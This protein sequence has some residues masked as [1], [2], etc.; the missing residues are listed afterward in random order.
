MILSILLA[1]ICTVVC[2]LVAY[3][4]A[5]VLRYIN[6][7]NKGLVIV[8]LILPMWMN[9]IL[10]ILALQMILNK[11]GILNMILSRFSIGPFEMLNTRGAIIFGMVY[12]FLPYMILPIYNAV[13]DIDADLLDA[14]SDLGASKPTRLFK[15]I[16][17]L[18]KPGIISGITMVFIPALTSFVIPDVLGGG[19]I[20]LI[21]NVIEQE[22]VTS[23]NWHL[24]AGLSFALLIFVIIGLL[25]TQRQETKEKESNVW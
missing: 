7:T 11:N 14:A 3:P 16:L 13:M 4:L 19:K 25:F 10:R 17:P 23:M 5:L 2:F 20:Q 12:D 9:S 8:I 1:L 24:G 15:I 6:F 22:F 18:S 21:G